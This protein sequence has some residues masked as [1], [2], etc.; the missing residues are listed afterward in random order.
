MLLLD[1]H[2]WIWLLLGENRLN[3]SGLLPLIRRAQNN[4]ELF[5]SSISLW[6]TCMLANKNRIALHS[7]PN[8]WLLNSIEQSGSHVVSLMPDVAADS[9]ALPGSFH[10]DPA[11]RII[12]A[13]ARKI[14][15]ELVTFD[16]KIL[17]YG[18]EGFVKV[19][20]PTKA[21]RTP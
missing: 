14:S 17:A 8:Q 21:Q 3:N 9:C 19:K 5:I 6:E 11:D 16:K 10:G 1:T 20:G 15:A 7:P 12:V 2:V 13:S 18:K 4:S